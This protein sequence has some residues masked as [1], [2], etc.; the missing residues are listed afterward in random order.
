MRLA[1]YNIEFHEEEK[2]KELNP[3]S[4]S[5]IKRY[6]ECPRSYFENYIKEQKAKPSPEMIFG[7]AVHATLEFHNKQRIEGNWISIVDLL[8]YL[9]EYIEDEFTNKKS[10]KLN[11]TLDLKK[12]GRKMIHEYFSGGWAEKFQPLES[13]FNF[14]MT[15][16]GI[17]LCGV[18]DL[19]TTDDILLDYKTTVWPPKGMEAASSIQLSLYT[20]VYWKKFGEWPKESRLLYMPKKG[21]FQLLP[22]PSESGRRTVAQVMSAVDV[23]KDVAQ[24]IKE[25]RYLPIPTHYCQYCPYASSCP[26][27][28]GRD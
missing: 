4:F 9:D 2:R 16:D 3:L 15:I 20:L 13:E 1:D 5:R 19:V 24:H 8:D 22:S 17:P 7:K 27:V 12:D 26:A 10:L 6:L 25:E 21:D 23:L 18:V 11:Q 28:G 14:L